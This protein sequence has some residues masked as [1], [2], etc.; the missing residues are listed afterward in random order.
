MKANFVTSRAERL[1]YGGY[2]VGQNI[3]FI[4][5]LSFLAMFY[6]DVVGLSTGAVATL[7][8]VARIWDAVNDPILGSLVDRA[9]PKKGKFK[10]WVSA[11]I[12][13]MPIA[14]ILVFW[15]MKGGGTVNLTYAYITYILWGMIYTISDVPIFALATSMTDNLDERVS[16]ISIGR[17]AAGIAGMIASVVGAPLI[18][19][20]GFQTSVMILMAIAFITMVPLHFI[21]K[22]RVLHP[23]KDKVTLKSMA[24][25]VF[26]NKYLLAFYGSAICILSFNFGTTIATY[27]AKWNLGDL[28]LQAVIMVSSMGIML[29][30]PLVLPVMIRKWG[31]RKLYITFVS[32]GIVFTLIQYVVGYENF[33]LFLVIN[34]IKAA[35]LYTPVLM[36][37]MFSADCAEYGAYITG[38]RNEGLTFSIQTFSTKLSQAVAGALPVLLLG[39]FG[40]DGQAE[41]QTARALEGIWLQMTLFPLI[42]FVIGLVIFILFYKLKESDVENMIAEMEAK[43]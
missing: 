35:G 30:I 34:A 12:V 42:G 5:V 21:V 29:F 8:L 2:F 13:L 32:I 20:L 7:F 19:S 18:A 15:N 26:K 3:I 39:V 14:T 31:K 43:E 24:T 22:E 33:V 41:V 11:T 28:S 10:P 17:F 37:G 16:L 38:Q 40:Y 25:A 9:T 4:T 6:T 36:M 27:F 1:S 23:K